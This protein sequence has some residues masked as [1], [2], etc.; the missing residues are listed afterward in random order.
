M[1]TLKIIIFIILAGLVA[2]VA[3]NFS[4]FAGL[5]Q[6]RTLPLS[7]SN[8][9]P[10]AKIEAPFEENEF[11][12]TVNFGDL[13]CQH[14][15]TNYFASTMLD[16]I[17]TDRKKTGDEKLKWAPS[18]CESAKLKSEDMI[19]NNYFEHVSPN[20]TQPWHWI[21]VAGYKYISV[22]ENL[23]L[24][25]FSPEK[26][27]TALMASQGHRENILNRDF[28]DFGIYYI[29]GKINGEDAFVLVQHFA[30][31]APDKLPVKY[32]CET[33]K[34]EKSLKDLKKK[35]N[36][37][38]KY[39]KDA[40]DTRNQ[41]KDADQNTKEVDDYIDYL[42]DKEKEVNGYIQDINDYLAK[43]SS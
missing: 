17:N 19:N 7:Q 12:K 16:L 35:K 36:E 8:I 2:F 21:E 10:K 43:C 32:I 6:K 22:G 30:A 24:N 20:G 26:A 34:A 41:L 29:R 42:N 27:H 37:I 25:Y 40:K 23:A 3:V 38:E 15:E 39:L 13:D 18:L 11:Q 9:L 14:P 28:Q 1:K 31:P 4:F 5:I 33:D